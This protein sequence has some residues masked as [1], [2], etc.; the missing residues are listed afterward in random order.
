MTTAVYGA[1]GDNQIGFVRREGGVNVAIDGIELSE[2]G[3][4][5]DV[6]AAVN[7]MGFDLAT[8]VVDRDG[9]VDDMNVAESEGGGHVN[10]VVNGAVYI[11][12]E[13]PGPL[14]VCFDFDPRGAGIDVDVD[15]GEVLRVCRAF[16]CVDGDLVFVPSDDFDGA[17]GVAEGE[18][19]LSGDSVGL[20][21]FFSGRRRFG[22]GERGGCETGQ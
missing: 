17:I 15:L 7:R 22:T 14:V 1:G 20:R 12:D 19:G 13:P 10:G 5:G 21:E 11:I 16:F 4:A 8:N 18:F 6:D 9:G 3:D 2:G